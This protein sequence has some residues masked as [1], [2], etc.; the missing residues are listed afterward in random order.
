VASDS[1]LDETLIK[2]P[3]GAFSP[4]PEGLPDLM[5]LEESPLIEEGDSF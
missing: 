3:L 4:S 5:G 2:F 1:Q